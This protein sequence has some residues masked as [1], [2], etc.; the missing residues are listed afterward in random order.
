MSNLFLVIDFGTTSTKS[1]LVDLDSGDF[2]ALQRL[3]QGAP[4]RADSAGSNNRHELSL[5]EL[6]ER[7]STICHDAWQHHHFEGIVLCSEMHGFAVI[8]EE[9]KLA[10]DFENDVV[11][12]S[13]VTHAGEI[14]NERVRD[15]MGSIG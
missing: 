1:A 6:L 2:I 14:R 15:A 11:G 7:F 13:T 4:T 12:P 10:L 8:D 3:S 5:T 9:G